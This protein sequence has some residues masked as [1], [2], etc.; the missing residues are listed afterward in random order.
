[1]SWLK[2]AQRICEEEEEEEDWLP[3][4][5]TEFYW[6]QL[7]LLCFKDV[8]TGAGFFNSLYFLFREKELSLLLLI[9]TCMY[10]C[11]W[12]IMIQ[13]TEGIVKRDD[14]NFG[15]GVGIEEYNTRQVKLKLVLLRLPLRLLGWVQSSIPTVLHLHRPCCWDYFKSLLIYFLVF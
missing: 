3:L 9:H 12:I 5:I 10:M 1:L 4:L 13:K 15:V 6:L 11:S 8:L 14:D 7:A 2:E